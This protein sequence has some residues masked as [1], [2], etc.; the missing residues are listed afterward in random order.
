MSAESL[1]TPLGMVA[2]AFGLFAGLASLVVILGGAVLSL[3]F[4]EPG[5][6]AD[7]V[8]AVLPREF[9]ISV[10]LGVTVQLV[11]FLLVLLPGFV[12]QGAGVARA[13]AWAG[14]A[15]L[16]YPFLR[17]R[18]WVR[19]VASGRSLAC[20]RLYPLWLHTLGPPQMGFNGETLPMVSLVIVEQARSSSP[21]VPP[22]VAV[23]PGLDALVC[24]VGSGFAG[25]L[26]L[27]RRSPHRR[28]QQLHLHRPKET[29]GGRDPQIAQIPREHI[30]T[31]VVVEVVRVGVVVLGRVVGSL[32]VLGRVGGRGV[33]LV[34][35]GVVRVVRV[36]RAR[37]PPGHRRWATRRRLVVAR[38]VASGAGPT[39][40]AGAA[41][42]VPTG[43]SPC[44]SGFGVS[45]IPAAVV[46][47]RRRARSAGGRVVAG[48]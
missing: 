44:T 1:K 10:G 31:P 23:C 14:A 33:R 40:P 30:G 15:L 46:G 25:G 28:K 39:R 29:V 37:R 19:L 34:V 48:P 17:I 45:S 9:L 47:F 6:P 11:V 20:D 36:S 5:L 21:G 26:R 27:G 2:A 42:A 7:A 35:V 24:L 32:V 16:A 41:A 22:S 12:W 18:F 4:A 13:A 3:R 38:A 43:G 8:V